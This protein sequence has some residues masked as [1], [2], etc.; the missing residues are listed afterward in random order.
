MSNNNKYDKSIIDYVKKYELDKVIE[1]DEI[2]PKYENYT[3]VEKVIEVSSP[4]HWDDLVRLHKLV[5][6]R[7]VT[8]VLEFGVGYS[9]LVLAHALNHNKEHYGNQ[10]TK[11]LR[12]SNPFELHTVDN[13]EKYLTITKNKINKISNISERVHFHRSSV[14]M[15]E[16][17]GRIVTYYSKLP[18]ICPDLIYLD[19]PGQYNVEGDIRNITTEHPDRVPMS[20][21]ILAIEHF[22][23]PGTYIIIDGRTANARFINANFQRNWE[24]ERDYDNDINSF[25][26]VEDPLGKYNKKQLELCLGKTFDK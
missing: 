7:K 3:A 1:F 23:M 14:I 6:L 12:R 16:W 24:Y 18:N 21:D 8:T 5:I 26:L 17:Q 2:K 20:A 19:G 10:V 25:E 22:L 4:P 11:N 15:G 13:L 9:T